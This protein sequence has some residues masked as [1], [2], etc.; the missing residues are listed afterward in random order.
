MAP[1]KA[2]GPDG[3]P[4]L[5]FQHFWPMIEGDVT[6]SM[7]SWL[8]LGTLPHPVNHT[9]ITLIPKKK[10]PSS[11][12][13]YRPISLCNVLYKIFSKVLAN[14]LKKLLN[15]VIIE[16]QS[17]FAKG[18]LIT[19]NILIAFETLHCMKNY[20]SGTN[21]FMALKLDM[22][23]AY[24]RVEWVYLEILMRKMG[25]CEQWIG[26][27]MVCVKTVT[28]SIL[29]NGESKG[30]IHPSRGLRQGDPLSPFLFLLCTEGLHGLIK[31]AASRGNIKGYSLCR[32]GPKLTHLFFADDS[33]LFCRANSTECSKVMDLLS[34]YE[35]VSGQ[36]INREKTT[37]FFSKSVTK[38]DIQII[39]GVLGVR[40]IQHYE[41]YLGLPS[42]TG[43]GKKASFNYIKERIWRKLLSQASREVLIKAVIQAIPTYTMGYFK[44]PIGLCNEIEVM[45]RKF[46]WGQRGDK[47]K[48]HWLKW[49]EMTKFKSE[50]G[51][52]FRD[53][54]LHNE[55]LLAKQAWRLLQD[56]SSLFY[57]VFKPRFFPNC[58]IMEAEESSRGS[59][60]WRSILYGRDVIKRGA[61]WRI[62]TGQKVQ[63]WQHTW[64]P[65][66]PPTRVLSPILEGWEK[67]TVDVLINEENRTWN[68]E[69]LAG[70]FVPEEV[71][72]IKRIP[73]SK[74]PTEDKL[75]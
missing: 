35:D 31:N 10:N 73:L 19:D 74:H 29:V 6:H 4:P 36:K 68:D 61:C 1:M 26:L 24:D 25:F 60:A 17:A 46:W 51:M 32:Q 3:M 44:L 55:S 54:T 9:F 28:Y 75:Y 69:V 12:S 53:L 62:G 13:E 56:Q 39:K 64:L 45:T 8:N 49:S 7:L 41:K 11:V 72:L 43:K 37:L 57:K 27:I 59:Y 5:F 40:E 58:T 16:H 18:R 23:K 30:L 50:G 38:V 14:K 33:L 21:G 15:S 65:S 42:L 2:P 67:T 20:N 52:G 63:I 66:K 71:E 48:I 22:S 34:V 70:L 47:R